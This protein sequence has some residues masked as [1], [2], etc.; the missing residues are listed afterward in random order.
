MPSELSAAGAGQA[1]YE[2][3]STT[4]GICGHTDLIYLAWLIAC[5]AAFYVAP[6]PLLYIP[7]LLGAIVLSW[8]RPDLALVLV[9]LFA[10]YF[11]APKHVG[12]K[13]LP[14]SEVFLAV[15]LAVAALRVALRQGPGAAAWMRLRTSPFL[16]PGLLFLAAG[17]ASTVLAADGHAAIYA[18][19][20]LVLEPI[21]FF[22]LLLLFVDRRSM[23]LY[24]FGALVGGGLSLAIIAL[25]QLATQQ[26][27]FLTP[28]GHPPLARVR[29]LYGSPDNLGLLFDRLLPVWFA[30]AVCARTRR[31][32]RMGLWSVGAILTLVLLLTFSRGAW[33]GVAAGCLFVLVLVYPWGRR[34]AVASLLLV[35]A[36]ALFYGPTVVHALQVGHANTG[37]RRVDVWESSLAMIRDHP[38]TGVGPDNFL[39][40]YA[41]SHDKYLKGCSPGLNYLKPEAGPEP[42][43]SHP[44][45]EILDFWLSTGIAGLAAFLWLQ[46]VFWTSAREIW[47]APLQSA[48]RALILGVMASMIAALVHGAID[49]FYFLMD[50]ATIFWL[51]CAFVSFQRWHVG[52]PAGLGTEPHEENAT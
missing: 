10:P 22:C 27:Q 26:Q 8:Y 2:D 44:H 6:T 19:G 36:G 52:R 12:A 46:G 40:Y 51:L 35:A 9:P 21:A 1:V 16:L 15:D 11:M 45:D 5:G 34:L 20:Q 31:T 29:A 42:C 48:E 25:V 50:L 49:N 38:I 18:Y 28:I 24:L 4:T 3:A 7:P 33:L 47:R 17:G 39:H 30:C 14:P 13:L 43:L 23:W 37:L 32:Q 41:P